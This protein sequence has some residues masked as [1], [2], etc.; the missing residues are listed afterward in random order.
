VDSVRVTVSTASGRQPAWSPNGRELF[1]I[2]ADQALMSV[3]VDAPAG[4]AKFV[5]G[6]PMKLHDGRAYDDSDNS[7][8]R[9]R[10]YEVSRDGRFLRIKPV[11]SQAGTPREA[12]VVVVNWLEELKRLVPSD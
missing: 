5:A 10:S 1:Y 4:G 8:N 6:A 12:L 9:G 7:P 11:P 2:A 3:S